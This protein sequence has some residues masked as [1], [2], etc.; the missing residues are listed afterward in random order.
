[1]GVYCIHFQKVKEVRYDQIKGDF[2]PEIK[3]Q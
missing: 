3:D 2:M 1:M